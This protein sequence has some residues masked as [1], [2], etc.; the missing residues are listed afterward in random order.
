MHANFHNKQKGETIKQNQN[1]ETVREKLF[2]TK[3]SS[4]KM[5]DEI[6]SSIDRIRETRLRRA[7]PSKFKGEAEPLSD[8]NYTKIAELAN[9]ISLYIHD[10]GKEQAIQDFQ[11]GLNLLNNYKKKVL[12]EAKLQLNED[13]DFGEKTYSALLDVLEK[14]PLN[15]IQRYVKLGALN[16]QIWNTKNHQKI[17]T[18]KKIEQVANKMIERNV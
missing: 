9:F 10:V 17:N 18:D 1:I 2:S 12:T 15:V 6:R 14:Y 5:N 11:V 7:R 13:G 16:N 3:P 4:E 8:E